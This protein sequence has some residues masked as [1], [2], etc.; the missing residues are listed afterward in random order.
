[1]KM[2]QCINQEISKFYFMRYWE[3]NKTCQTGISVIYQLIYRQVITFSQEDVVIS[4]ECD[5]PNYLLYCTAF[6]KTR[7]KVIHIL[8]PKE[9]SSNWKGSCV[10]LKRQGD[11]NDKYSKEV[12]AETSKTDRNP[13]MNVN[14]TYSQILGIEEQWTNQSLVSRPR[15]APKLIWIQS[16]TNC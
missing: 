12:M 8:I 11:W 4:T 3:L 5:R 10:L 2:S 1:M 16:S 13:R 15:A 6:A 14:N 9:T 7:R